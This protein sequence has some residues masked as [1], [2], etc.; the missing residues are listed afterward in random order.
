MTAEGK[1]TPDAAG[2][3]RGKVS[4][5]LRR[6]ATLAF[7]ELPPR[8][9]ALDGY[10]QGPRVDPDTQ[11]YSFDHHA[12]CVRH[13]TLSACEM[14]LDALRVGLDP[15]GHTVWLNDL[16]ADS[17]LAGW[18]LTCPDG[19]ADERVAAAV[20]AVGRLDALGPADPG[21][22]LSL[23]LRWALSPLDRRTGETPLRT[24]STT[25]QLDALEECFSR[26]D[27]WLEAG[28]PPAMPTATTASDCSPA[29]YE[30]VHQGAGW[31][32]ATA[33]AGLGAFRA[34]YASGVHAAVVAR[35]LP[36]GTT[37]FS[38]GKASEF[39][40]GFDVPRI[41]SALRAAE[42]RINPSQRD[43]TSWG[44]GSTIGGSPRNP[45]GSASR[46]S[47]EEVAGVVEAVL[48]EGGS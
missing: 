19:A 44:G 35:P 11:R 3:S 13:A 38:V 40:A 25:Q 24:R 26:L 36:D 6:G 31:V 7:E 14:V 20:R 39:V 33:D 30:L 15:T 47:P 8:S 27:K 46:L 42:R 48:R 12:G 32:L 10:V 18:L 2:M 28:A 22:G 41:L 23:A 37:E 45:D 16:D 21:P 5:A 4:L 29:K 17:V 1:Y 9:I 43:A 34:L